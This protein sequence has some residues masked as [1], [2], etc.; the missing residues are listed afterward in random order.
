MSLAGRRAEETDETIGFLLD[1]G[2][3]LSPWNFRH[4]SQKMARTPSDG[5]KTLLGTYSLLI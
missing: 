5:P 2:S 4:M 1:P 3:D